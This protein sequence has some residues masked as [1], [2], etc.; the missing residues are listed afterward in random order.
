MLHLKEENVESCFS[1]T[2]WPNSYNIEKSAL[3]GRE[4]IH[5]TLLEINTLQI[6]HDAL[7]VHHRQ[8]PYLSTVIYQGFHMV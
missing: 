4:I 5:L 2:T 1:P 7:T 8:V 3:H 6:T